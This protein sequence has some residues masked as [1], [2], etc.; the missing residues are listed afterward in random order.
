MTE[1]QTCLNCGNVEVMQVFL[2]AC[3]ELLPPSH[4]TDTCPEC[5]FTGLHMCTVRGVEWDQFI[6]IN[7]F[8]PDIP[9]SILVRDE[10][11]Y[12]TTDPIQDWQ[13]Y[14]YTCDTPPTW[15][16]DNQDWGF[17]YNRCEV[18][19]IGG[20]YK[21]P[22]KYDLKKPQRINL[23][24]FVQNGVHSFRWK[25]EDDNQVIPLNNQWWW[26]ECHPIGGFDNKFSCDP[27]RKK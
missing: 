12:T 13:L 15:N 25:Y 7:T 1:Q 26:F 8:S 3:I 14:R 21:L 2:Q 19:D 6:V 9:S 5:N 22:Q 18:L 10:K 4:Y 23:K 16:E 11:S 27:Y 24:D 17:L 20:F